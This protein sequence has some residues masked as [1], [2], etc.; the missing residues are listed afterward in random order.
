MPDAIVHRLTLGPSRTLIATLSALHVTGLAIVWIV[1]LPAWSQAGLSILLA[2]SLIHAVAMHGRR[3]LAR[4]TLELNWGSEPGW[5]GYKTRT[6]LVETGTVLHSTFVASYLTVIN[7]KLPGSVWPRHVVI[8]PDACRADEFRQLR[9]WLRLRGQP[10]SAEA[11][12][13]AE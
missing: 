5:L 13:P 1:T 7:L 9:V 6:G 8:F 3:A 10:A 12:M 11:H 2:A 4:S